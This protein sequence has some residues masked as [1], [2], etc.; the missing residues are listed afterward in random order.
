MADL[1]DD[2]LA[3]STA[4]EYQAWLLEPDWAECTSQIPSSTPNP[5][6]NPNLNPN[7]PLAKQP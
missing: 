4:R 3:Q 7:P 1:L 2:L 5:L 6:P